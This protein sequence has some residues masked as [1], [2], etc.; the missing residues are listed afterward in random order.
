MS[1]PE[2]L[3]AIIHDL[4]ADLAPVRRLRPPLVRAVMWLAFVAAL[5]S[6]M[7]A[8]ADLP[9]IAHRLMGAPDMWLAVLGSSLTAILGAMA[10]FELSVPDRKPLWALLPVPGLLLWIGASG[11]GCLR[12]WIVPYTD[13]IPAGETRV[14]FLFIVA[15]SIPLSV[16]MIAMVRKAC[17]LRPSLT[18]AVSGISIAAGAATLLNFFHPYDAAAIDLV[19]HIIAV[20]IV[21][22]A[23]QALAGHLLRPLRSG[24]AWPSLSDARLGGY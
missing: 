23:N 4:G 6:V 22:G 13:D 11:L 15:V 7:A 9:E 16:L 19:V 8:F 5:G 12:N 21:V 24:A 18:A 3:D 1:N 14:C 10:V 20:G 17:P 2:R